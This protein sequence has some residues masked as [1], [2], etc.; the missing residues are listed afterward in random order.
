MTVFI[1]QNLLFRDWLA[2]VS[3]SLNQ[4]EKGLLQDDQSGSTCRLVVPLMK[5]PEGLQNQNLSD[6]IDPLH[7]KLNVNM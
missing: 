4:N 6:Y 3:E 7:H 2:V 1:S 5:S